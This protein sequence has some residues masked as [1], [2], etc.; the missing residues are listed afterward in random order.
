MMRQEN[1]IGHLFIILAA[2][3]IVLAGIKS[4]AVIVVPF[5][6]SIFLAIIFAPMFQ[7]LNRKGVPEGISL[8]AVIVLFVVLMG[9]VGML[10][11][12]SVQDFTGK[13]GFYE[14][15]SHQQLESVITML[16]GLGLELSGQQVKEMFDPAV[17]MKYVAGTLKSLGSVLT[18]S[19]VILLTVVFILLESAQFKRKIASLS[20]DQALIGHMREIID[21][22]EH[23][24]V[25]KAVIS[26]LTGITVTVM[27][28]IIGVD[29]AVLWGVVAFMLNFIPNIGSIIA[30]VPTVIL[31][32]IQ[33]GFV[34]AAIVAIGY[35]VINILVGSVI[36]PKVM[37]QGLGLSTLVVFLS[38]IFW[39][40][41]L[42]PVGMLLSIP[43][44]IMVKIALDAQANTR[45]IAVLLGTGEKRREKS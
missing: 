31:A 13:L 1:S 24:M 29:Y 18:N 16:S 35:V 3:V 21:K 41:L 10:V 39:G 26:A 15:Q 9:L 45:W 4:A 34:S 44:T 6:L 30:A 14:A 43:L 22:I 11:G 36:E 27:L 2:V 28:Q 20:A 40:W 8:F 5:L 33:L 42:G 19:L 38:L 25:L 12:S 23:Y 32:F 37:G 17:V 7:W